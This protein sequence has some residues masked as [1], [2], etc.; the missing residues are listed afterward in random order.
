MIALLA[1]STPSSH[2]AAI[3]MMCG[4]KVLGRFSFHLAQT[5]VEEMASPSAQVLPQGFSLVKLAS[6]ITPQVECFCLLKEGPF[7]PYSLGN[8]V[9]ILQRGSLEGN[10]W[11][12]VSRVVPAFQR[13]TANIT[14]G[15]SSQVCVLVSA[16]S[17]NMTRAIL[18]PSR[19]RV[20]WRV[21]AAKI[22][23]VCH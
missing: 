22:C 18:F 6:L 17:C 21:P 20:F 8:C 12:A 4:M 7:S 11:C 3:L 9:A 1:F 14:G 13:M 15:W 19:Y 5:L 16:L 2:A 23:T 10:W